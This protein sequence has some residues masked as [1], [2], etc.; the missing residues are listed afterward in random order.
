MLFGLQKAKA[1]LSRVFVVL[2]ALL[3]GGFLLRLVLVF[4]GQEHII[5]TAYRLTHMP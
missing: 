2:G 5:T 4:T 3:A 1:S